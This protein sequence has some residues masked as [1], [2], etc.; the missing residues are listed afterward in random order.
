MPAREVIV[1]REIGSSYVASA[2][3]QV[4]RRSH[5]VTVLAISMA[6]VIGPTPPGTGVMAAHRSATASKSTS[7][8]IRYPFG[9][10][11]FLDPVDADI[12]HDRAVADVIFAEESRASDRGDDDVGGACDPRKI[13][14]ARMGDGDRGVTGFAAPHEQER[15]RLSDDHAATHHHD[16]CAC[17]F[18]PDFLEKAHAA[19]RRARNESCGVIHR[20][21]GHIYGMKAVDIFSRIDCFDDGLLVDVR[22]RRGLDE[23]AVYQRVRVEFPHQRDE[24]FLRACPREAHA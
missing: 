5:A 18:D 23:D 1:L 3:S 10:I 24:P 4:A 21:L 17:R 12:D 19:Q 15:H 2:D 13:T 7:P 16:V 22:R 6:I 20:E 8:T 9:G 11:R 14:R